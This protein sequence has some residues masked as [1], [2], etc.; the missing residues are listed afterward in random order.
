MFSAKELKVASSLYYF[1]DMSYSEHVRWLQENMIF[2]LTV[3]L[4]KPCCLVK[5]ASIQLAKS[6]KPVTIIGAPES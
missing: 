2:S 5:T 1:K 6:F 3:T 4:T